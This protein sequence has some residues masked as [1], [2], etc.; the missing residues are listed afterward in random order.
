MGTHVDVS[1]LIKDFQVIDNTILS[2]TLIDTKNLTPLRS[3]LNNI[4]R[5]A[6]RLKLS[7]QDDTFYDDGHHKTNLAVVEHLLENIKTA[8]DFISNARMDAQNRSIRTLSLISTICL[9]LSIL[10]GFFGMNFGFMGI[11]PG[12]SG[13]LRWKYAQ[14][15]LWTMVAGVVIV[16]QIAFHTKIL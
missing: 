13:I 8:E 1:E 6:L 10:T 4:K 2:W 12:T 3:D 9:P 5:K 7:F 11:D 14:W 16:V 15:M